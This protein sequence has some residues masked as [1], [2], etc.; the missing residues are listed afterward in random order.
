MGDALANASIF[1]DREAATEMA[2]G[3]EDIVW[4]GEWRPNL[5]IDLW[6]QVWNLEQ[7]RRIWVGL[8]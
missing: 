7:I 8:E 3:A 4:L 1:L 2:F 5:R 6:R